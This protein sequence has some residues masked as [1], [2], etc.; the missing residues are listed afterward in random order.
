MKIYKDIG[1]STKDVDEA[2]GIVSFYI[3]RFDNL[4]SD[5]DIIKAGAYVRSIKERGP[6]S[7]KPRVK[8]LKNHN[9]IH[10]P[11]KVMELYEDGSG[12]VMVSQLSKSTLGRDT[13][14]EYQEGIITEHSHGFEVLEEEYSERE[15]ANII[16]EV[17][18]WEGS[19]LNA[20]G[21]NEMTPV[22]GMKSELDLI[23]EIERRAKIGRLSDEYLQRLESILKNHAEG[24]Q[25]HASGSDSETDSR[26]FI[27]NY[28]TS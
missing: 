18:L 2:K 14:I 19:T 23:E 11:G 1:F 16:K 20:W 22:I 15:K 8:H 26:D 24:S 6:Q 7:S 13:L 10:T 12:V 25:S 28:L 27:L 3:A 4:D 9:P 17:K 5:G 21:A